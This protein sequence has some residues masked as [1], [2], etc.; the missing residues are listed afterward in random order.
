MIH[1]GLEL[2]KKLLKYPSK[3]EEIN[4]LWYT[5]TVEYS[6]TWEDDE[7]LDT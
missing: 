7:F 4:R 5:H 1:N 3:L 2:D 6:I